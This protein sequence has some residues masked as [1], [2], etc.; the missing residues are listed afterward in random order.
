MHYLIT[1]GTGFI[2]RVLCSRLRE[3]GHRVSVLTRDYAKARLQLGPEIELLRELQELDSNTRIDVIINLA[4]APIADRRW[5]ARRKRVLV[6][7][8]V[9]VTAAIYRLVQRLAHRPECLVTASAVGYYGASDERPL[10]EDAPANS[11]FTHELCK[12]WEE[13]A[14]KIE[15]LGVRTCIVRLGIVLGPKGGMLQ[16]LLTPFRLGLGGRLGDGRQFMSWVH[17][18]D[19]IEVI[20]WLSTNSQASGVYNLTAPEP[21]RNAEFTR[22]LASVL[23]RPALFPMPAWLVR[24]LF[25]EMGD[26]LLLHG[27]CVVPVRL[28]EAGYRFQ[29]EEITEALRDSVRG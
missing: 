18:D 13:E 5:T 7:S 20:H 28:Q 17:R 4:G 10:T 11:E 24:L 14:R 8:R 23:R 9:E 1:G 19:V 12:R 25:G 27:Q 6:D 21:V 3:E 22:S 15:A 29:Y 2:G 16:K 26:R